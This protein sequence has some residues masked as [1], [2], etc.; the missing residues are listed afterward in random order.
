M[1][2]SA[3]ILKHSSHAA[4]FARSDR[5]SAIRTFFIRPTPQPTAPCP[6]TR[7]TP[8]PIF[9][10]VFPLHRNFHS[11]CAARDNNNSNRPS[12]YTAAHK[13]P[14]SPEHTR[15]STTPNST[16]TT[17]EKGLRPPEY[18]HNYPRFFRQLALSLPHISRPSRDDFLS[19][20]NGIV[21]RMRVRVR[22]FFIRNFR[23]FNA[24]DISAFVTWF[25]VG[26]GLWILI[27]TSVGIVT[28]Y[29]PQM[30]ITLVL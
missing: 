11:S 30:L 10:P 22:W 12:T 23:K 16:P 27:G 19:A 28:R 4:T 5:Y 6:L 15:T 21:Q 7:R 9:P 18:E 25:L 17:Q 3:L 14:A 1:S 20:A 2:R 26:Q 29:F 13:S 8:A 24:D